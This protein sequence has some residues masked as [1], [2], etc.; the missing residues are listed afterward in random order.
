MQLSKDPIS[1]E[2]P[3]SDDGSNLHECIPDKGA[4][5][6]VDQI[7]DSQLNEITDQLLRGL[8]PRDERILRMRFG[9]GGE[10]EHTL[11]EIGERFNLSRERIRQIET[12]ALLRIRASEESRELRAYMYEEAM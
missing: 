6:A 12:K 1:L 9:V 10:S 8:S 7:E 3:F 4:A 2:T 5:S 11:E